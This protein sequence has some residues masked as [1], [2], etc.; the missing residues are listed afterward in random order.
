MSQKQRGKVDN[1]KEKMC[2]PEQHGRGVQGP[3]SM[4]EAGA[5]GEK[6]QHTRSNT[7]SLP[8]K[9]STPQ[10][11]TRTSSRCSNASTSRPVDPHDRGNT[12]ADQEQ[13]ESAEINIFQ[14]MDD[15][16]QK[17]NELGLGEDIGFEEYYGGY[18]MQ[19]P[20]TPTIDTTLKLDP[21]DMREMAIRH[22]VYRIRAFK[23]PIRP[24]LCFSIIKCCS[25]CT[26]VFIVNSRYLPYPIYL[27][28]FANAPVQIKFVLMVVSLPTVVTK[29]VQA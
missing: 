3:D 28:W 17:M 14:V 7:S 24:C 26:S 20:T 22:A 23:V 10:L 1:A 12:A 11:K 29:C 27:C 25:F 4:T 6:K 9:R 16:I 19:L 18:M 8:T 21:I 13:R 2:P 5:A 15:I